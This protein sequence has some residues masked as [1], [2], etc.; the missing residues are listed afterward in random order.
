M[1]SSLA[2]Q[3]AAIN[4]GNTQVIDRKKRKQ[5]H[6]VSLI[7]TPKVAAGQ[8]YE[9]IYSVAIEGLTDLEQLDP[10]FAAFRNNIFADTSISVDRLTQVSTTFYLCFLFY[11]IFHSL[12]SL[13]TNLTD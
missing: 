12:N 5:I 8:D 7:F 6:S 9:T 11:L 3:L 2:S 1:V 4:A 13:L 10:R